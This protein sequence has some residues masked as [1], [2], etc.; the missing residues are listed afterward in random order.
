[1]VAILPGTDR[2]ARAILLLAH[3]DVVEAK[4]SDWTRDPFTLVEENGNFYG[5]GVA[6]DK[7]MAAIWADTMVRLKSDKPLR[8]TVKLALTC[9][10]ESAS[11][12][13]GAQYLATSQRQLIDAAFALNEGGGGRYGADGRPEVMTM[14]VGEKHY[15]DFHLTATN[16]GGHSSMPR[17]DNA[18]YRLAHALTAVEAYRFPVRLN[19]TTVGFLKAAGKA[20]PAPLGPAMVAL[21]SDPAD[22]AAA[23]TLATDPVL[24]GIIRTTCVATMV[25]AG[26]APNA[27][28]QNATANIN[29]RIVPGETVEGTRAALL[30]AIDDPGLSLVA[31]KSRNDIA[32]QPPLTPEIWKPAAALVAKYFP[33]VPFMPSMSTGATDGPFL[34]AAGIPVYGVPGLVAEADGGGIHG[35][36]EHIRVESVMKGRSFLYDLVR[37]YAS[38]GT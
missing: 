22:A 20:K 7:A 35:L 25:S 29:C 8:R 16:P 31:E 26:H 10:E 9:G 27:L 24:N 12:F 14:Q 36:N 3:V 6:D 17:P 33:G 11:A 28:P 37:D 23:G 2:K 38:N 21:A 13:N 18:I 30:A 34:S 1:L 5:R 19:D 32:R 15:A 4:R